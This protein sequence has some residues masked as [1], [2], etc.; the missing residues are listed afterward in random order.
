[1]RATWTNGVPQNLFDQKA[2]TSSRGSPAAQGLVPVRLRTA[3]GRRAS[4]ASSPTRSAARP[5]ASSTT[6]STSRAPTRGSGS[7]CRGDARAGA[8]RDAAPR[9]HGGALG[10]R[11]P[12]R[13][14]AHGRRPSRGDLRRPERTDDPRRHGEEALHGERA[15][16][17]AR[18]RVGRVGT[19]GGRDGPAPP[20]GQG[21]RRSGRRDGLPGRPQRARA[22]PRS[23]AGARRTA[24]SSCTSTAGSSTRTR[25]ST[26]R[27]RSGG[28]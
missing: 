23:R 19:D 16:P 27:S 10:G 5:S 18:R 15:A 8:G 22:R 1:M 7:S 26:S 11:L 12:R 24:A 3:T 25:R 4:G 14:L 2:R 6:A 21:L 17:R 20:R 9:L 13:G 28:T